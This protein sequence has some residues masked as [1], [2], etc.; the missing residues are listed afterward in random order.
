M[1]DRGFWF[2]KRRQLFISSHD[3]TL[4]V[5]AM[6]VNNPDCAPVGINRCGFFERISFFEN[7][8]PQIPDKQVSP[9][10]SNKHARQEKENQKSGQSL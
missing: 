7:F 10:S 6:R 9:A 1:P 2:H 8:V 4:S 3:E 5:A